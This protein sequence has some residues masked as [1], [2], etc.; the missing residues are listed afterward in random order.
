MLAK[1]SEVVPATHDTASDAENTGERLSTEQ[2]LYEEMAAIHGSDAASLEGKTDAVFYRELHKL[3]SVALCL[4]GGGIRS[5]SF[6]LGVLEALA[7]HPRPASGC[8]V[9]DQS[10]SFLRQFHY[11][12]TVSGGGYI[13]GCLSAWIKRSGYDSVWQR[14]VGRR[15]HPDQ[16]P[17]EL[18][19]LRAYSNYLTPRLGLFSADTWAA[20]ALFVRNLILNWLVIIPALCLLLFAIKLGAVKV[21][22]IYANHQ[23]WLPWFAGVAT[24]L[25]WWVLRF[26]TINRPTCNP[27]SVRQHPS[28]SAAQRRD[29]RRN[30]KTRRA[31]G[32]DEMHFLALSLL[33][34]LIAAICFSLYLT[35]NHLVTANWPLWKTALCGAGGAAVLYAVAWL[36]ALPFKRCGERREPLYWPR[37]LAAWAAAGLTFGALIGVGLHAFTHEYLYLLIGNL[38]APSK[39]LL[40]LMIYGVPWIIT[41]QLTAEM[42]FVGLT[43]WE[44]DSDADR[45]WFGRST[46]W[47]AAAAAVWLVVAFLILI[48]A[49]LA[50]Q[51]LESI[52]ARYGASIVGLGSGIVSAL[53]GASSKSPATDKQ[54]PKTWLPINLILVVATSV[55]LV[56]LVVGISVMMD[57]LLLGDSLL[58]SPL[59]GAP[60]AG[61]TWSGD[62]RW[63]LIGL[64]V[65]VLVAAFSWT[66]V[67]I[68]RF[69]IH[70]L[71]R[72]RLIRAYLG[73]SN[74]DRRPNPFTGFDERDNLK[75]AELAAAPEGS[76]RPF[77]VVNIALNVV[78]A[79]RLAWQERKAESFTATALHCGSATSSGSD[80][81]GLG[82]RRTGEYGDRNGGISLGTAVAISGAAASP[83]MGYHSSPLVTLLLALFNVRLGWWLGNPGKAGDRTYRKSG[84]LVA[85]VPYLFE[86]F[87]QTTDDRGYVYLS[88]GGH[89]ENLGLYEMIRRRCRCIVVSDAGCDPSYGFEDLGN[90]VRKIAIDFGIRI[91]FSELRAL[92][93]R[94]SDDSVIEGAYYAVGV[95]DYAT[96]PEHLPSLGNDSPLAGGAAAEKGYILYVK[97]GY[98]GSEGA[99]IVAY[100]A[101]HPAFPHETTG[102]QFFSES[103][104]ESYRTLGFEI[105]DSVFEEATQ[106]A[107]TI[108]RA[109][110]DSTAGFS[111]LDAAK[112]CDLVKA[113]EPGVIRKAEETFVMPPQDASAIIN[114]LDDNAREVLR[115][116]L[117]PVAAPAATDRR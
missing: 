46:G 23:S 16:E 51:L 88:D 110:E 12:S 33:P 32:A 90:A 102:D 83:N 57:Y 47:F 99:G 65:V 95:I 40:V 71:Y 98:H 9:A 116:I 61:A 37:E 66:H 63:L 19:W 93:K 64:G 27:T 38:N 109:A 24:L 4:S 79:S 44:R 85:I 75:M 49:D 92:K 14:L 84:P 81:D 94:P 89:F 52:Y 20:I 115:G 8:Q 41:S 97:P 34:A 56:V 11:L 67:N 108:S 106:N 103:Q 17:S 35:A 1:R 15:A 10:R 50:F 54:A 39:K 26:A 22:W 76:W 25:M 87:G 86:M 13:G 42:I 73:A 60:H 58:R 96:A 29:A 5:A 77:H 45:E 68:N 31:A 114:A 21:Y 100:A 101:G 70:A 6:A 117:A 43:S 3:N 7:V 104:F 112:V 2:V 28:G 72:N 74:P 62:F 113:L 59:M 91:E 53:F 30:E 69:S 78:A 36:T 55:F 82:Y 48:A 80:E 105:M 18:A 107:Y 111:V